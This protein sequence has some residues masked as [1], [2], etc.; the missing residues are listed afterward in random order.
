[1]VSI[2]ERIPNSFHGGMSLKATEPG[3]CGFMFVLARLDFLVML[4]CIGAYLTCFYV[5]GDVMWMAQCL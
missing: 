4:L 2:V 3:F 1:M 5:L